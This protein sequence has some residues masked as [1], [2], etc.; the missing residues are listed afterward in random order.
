MIRSG[1]HPHEAAL[2]VVFAVAGISG[3]LAPD[4]TSNQVL[5]TLSAPGLYVFFGVLA[6]G[7]LLALVGTFTKGLKGPTIE[8]FGLAILTLELLG[9]GV[10]IFGAVGPRGLLSALL[11]I[12]VAAANTVRIWQIVGEVKAVRAAA[13]VTRTERHVEGP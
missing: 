5:K 2:L 4:R 13:V 8:L 10:A 6:V 1:R 7:S 12:G 3:L 11:P 9:Y